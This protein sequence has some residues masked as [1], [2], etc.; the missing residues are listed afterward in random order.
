MASYRYPTAHAHGG[1]RGGG[2][3]VERMR[4]HGKGRPAEL[5]P[6][7]ERLFTCRAPLP[8]AAVALADG[9][10][11]MLKLSIGSPTR[12][13]AAVPWFDGEARAFMTCSRKIAAYMLLS[14][15]MP[16]KDESFVYICQ[17]NASLLFPAHLLR[18]SSPVSF[19]TR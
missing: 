12:Q 11:G 5:I 14:L 1:G 6:P 17:V 3:S 4:G 7:P 10:R 2:P 18:C 9:T 13:Q 16:M 8:A 19:I 15:Q